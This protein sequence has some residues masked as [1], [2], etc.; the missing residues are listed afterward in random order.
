M[1][2]TCFRYFSS[3][4]VDSLYKRTYTVC[5][6]VLCYTDDV[7]FL[8]SQY[9]VELETKNTKKFLSLSY[10]HL[11]DINDRRHHRIQTILLLLGIPSLFCCMVCI[12]SDD[13]CNSHI[14]MQTHVCDVCKKMLLNK[15]QSVYVIR[16][17]VTL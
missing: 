5:R 15:F 8:Y 1:L 11:L 3:C 4:H 13:V 9:Q 6:Y 14:Y 17:H 12:Y 16:T 2:L 10:S 7:K